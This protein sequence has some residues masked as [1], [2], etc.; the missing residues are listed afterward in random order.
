MATSPAED[1]RASSSAACEPLARAT[2]RLV[3]PARGSPSAPVGRGST[4]EVRS[5][6]HGGLRAIEKRPV[7]DDG[8]ALVREARFLAIARSPRLPALLHV[9][10]DERGPLLV[11]SE[12]TGAPLSSLRDGWEPVPA[13]LA[14]H[15]VR[16][17]A[18]AYDELHALADDDGPLACVHGDP[19]FTNLL[20][21]PIGGI[22]L[23]DFGD[24]TARGAPP[25][26]LR[27]VG[28]PPYA[29]PELLRAEAAPSQATDRYAVGALALALLSRAPLRPELEE[30]ASLHALATVGVDAAAIAAAPASL[31]AALASLVH[32]APEARPTSLSSLITALDG[33]CSPP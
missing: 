13:L 15:V 11:E 31:Q 22:A 27:Q 6:E 29:A 21:T 30:A 25:G 20:L 28:T 23:V 33:V 2:L 32:F 17:I 18:R 10:H 5:V 3:T 12:S 4:F 14:L 1:A 19:S 8:G 16:E 9:G 24:A 26:P 7:G